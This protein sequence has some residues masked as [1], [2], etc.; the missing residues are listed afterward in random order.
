[1]AR[2]LQHPDAVNRGTHRGAMLF[3]IAV[4][5]AAMLL[6]SG[7]FLAPLTTPVTSTADPGSDTDTPDP[8]SLR[9]PMPEELHSQWYTQTVA[10][11]IEVGGTAVV[12]I[13]YRNV[14]HT[15]WFKGGPS[16]IRLGE[17][18]PRRLPPAMRVDWLTP[19]RPAAQSESVVHE[20]QLVTFT[21]KVAGDAPGTYRLR[22]QPV[23]DGVKWL[24]DEGVFVDISVRG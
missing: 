1:M 24:A 8:A 3:T 21:F 19:D 10:P 2:P 11:V 16:E 17:V 6:L 5:A 20:R 14:G 4:A 23:V 7:V 18:G 12:T 22:V 15:P 13:Q 9:T